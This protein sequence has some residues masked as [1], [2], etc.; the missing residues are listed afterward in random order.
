MTL[1]KRKVTITD[2]EDTVVVATV[3]EFVALGAAL[4]KISNYNGFYAL[5]ALKVANGTS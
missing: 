4:D 5:I 2:D 3:A 1:G